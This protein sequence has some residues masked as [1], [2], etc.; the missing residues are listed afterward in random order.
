MSFLL[1]LFQLGFGPFS[2]P[3]FI[4]SFVLPACWHKANP[5]LHQDLVVKKMKSNAIS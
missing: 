4:L 2:G 3:D 5:D 1:D